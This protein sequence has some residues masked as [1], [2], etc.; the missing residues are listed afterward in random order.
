MKEEGMK[1]EE[2]MKVMQKPIQMRVFTWQGDQDVIMRP[3]DSIKHHL[4]YLNAGFLAIEPQ[5]GKIKAWVGGIDFGY[6][7][8]DHVKESTK[9]QVGS[10]F[11]PIVYAMAIEQSIAPCDF[12]LADRPTYIDDE[13]VSWTPRNSQ[14]D[15]EVRYSMRGALAYSVNTV[16]VKLI[17]M[18]G[19]DNTVD[20]AKRMGINSEVPDVPSIALGSS[21]ISL[22][23]MTAAYSCFANNGIPSP[24]F[25]ISSIQDLTGKIFADF[26]P[27]VSN[28]PVASQETIDLVRSMMQSVV[29]EGTASRLRWKYGV[30]NDVAGKT[31]TTQANADGWFMAVTPNLVVGTW[32]GGDD[33]RI[34]FRSTELG[35]GSNTALPMFAYFMKSV[36][37]DPKFEYISKAT[38]PTLP[39]AQRLRLDC[40][41]YELD[42]ALMDKIQ[43]GILEQD[44]LVM[45]DTTLVREDTFLEK[46]Y[47]R[48]VKMHQRAMQRDSL[49][50]LEDVI[51]IKEGG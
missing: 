8:F 44:S 47:K 51:R 45:L 21:S 25:S 22:M 31:G 4:Q 27:Q 40:D 32:V 12:I 5:T 39:Y 11:K 24:P 13:G 2:I 20:L 34:R 14:N 6:F 10:I 29:H 26:K 35:Q 16:S 50:R 1:E 37:D 48:K 19:V 15:Y 28:T 46:L 30:L 3:I 38:F 41:L 42:S 23:E 49:A 9:R 33:P 43:L 17:Q 36:N 18:A 7:Q